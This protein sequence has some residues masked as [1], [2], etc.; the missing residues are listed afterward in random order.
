MSTNPESAPGEGSTAGRY[1]RP[2]RDLAALVL[3]V[4]PAV[5]LFVA[6]IRLIPSVDGDTFGTRVQASFDGFVN[7]ASIGLP[8]LGVLLATLV[9]P[10]HPRAKLITTVALGQYAVQV[11][12]GV[13]FGFLVGLVSIAGFSVRFA[14]EEFLRR[15]AWLALLGIA[16]FAV[17]QIWRNLYY[18]PRPKP[19]PG[20]Y[21]QPAQA[22]PPYGPPQGGPQQYGT[23][24]GQ[25]GQPPA[26]YGPPLGQYGQPPG[27]YGPPPGQPGP[28]PGQQHPGQPAWNPPPP[29]AQPGHPPVG[30][31]HP[32]QTF[33]L[34][35]SAPPGMPFSGPPAHPQSAPPSAPP[36][37]QP[38]AQ[39]PGPFAPDPGHPQGAAP[40]GGAPY[41]PPRDDAYGAAPGY[42]RTEMLDPDR[43]GHGDHD[44]SRH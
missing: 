24:P 25:Y 14:F 23:P 35:Q 41:G 36:S 39:P 38:S 3:V 43:R 34:P 8:L 13:L 22:G 16:A 6:V 31:A 32:T 40:Y 42:E 26:Q 15:G 2:L 44:G 19:V 37:A 21:G 9:R 17:F 20:M 18:T 12:F 11:F 29:P 30:A 1:L 5:M 10:E 4:A 33:G 28:P 7:L 27:Q